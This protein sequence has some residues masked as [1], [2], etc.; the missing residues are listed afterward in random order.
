MRSCRIPSASSRRAPSW[1]SK[2]SRA[3]LSPE[4]R[5]MSKPRSNGAKPRASLVCSSPDWTRLY[6]AL[7]WGAQSQYRDEAVS[8]TGAPRAAGAVFDFVVGAIAARELSGYI[9]NQSPRRA[10]DLGERL[11]APGGRSL[12]GSRRHRG[13]GLLAHADASAHGCAGGVRCDVAAVPAGGRGLLPGGI[14]PCRS[15]ACCATPRGRLPARRSQT[16][17]RPGVVGEGADTA[18]PVGSRRAAEPREPGTVTV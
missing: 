4:R 14:R 15:C 11:A 3:R 5:A 10:V 8:D 17:F 12:R 6:L 18:G 13:P 16:A 2:S 1:R 9:L 7:V